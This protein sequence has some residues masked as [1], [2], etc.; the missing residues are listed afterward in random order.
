MK[1][2]QH[3]AA[4]AV[5]PVLLAACN[6]E[7]A[8]PPEPS[9]PTPQPGATPASGAAF[10]AI[11]RMDGAGATKVAC[12]IDK[13][14]AQLAA[15]AEINVQQGGDVRFVG[16]VSNAAKNVPA[17]FRIVLSDKSS[18]YAME[19]A[20]G[21]NRPDVAR[22]MKADG[23]AQAGFNVVGNLGEVPVGEYA[24]LLTSDVAGRREVCA[25]RTRLL[26]VATPR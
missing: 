8:P 7:A 18:S 1:C 5:L 12:A 2:W 4:L 10:A 9:A 11:D 16:W 15:R 22:V 24:V 3:L 13:V 21:I 25:T 23:L 19:A 17:G 14:N 26:V 6:R 20:A